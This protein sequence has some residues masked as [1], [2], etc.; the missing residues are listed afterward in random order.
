MTFYSGKMFPAEYQNTMFIARKG[1]WNRTVKFGFDVVN[2]GE[3]GKSSFIHYVN[4]RLGG[5]TQWSRPFGLLRPV[6]EIAM[7]ARRP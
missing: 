3:F 4:Q 7:L 2:D 1:S 5:A 6:D